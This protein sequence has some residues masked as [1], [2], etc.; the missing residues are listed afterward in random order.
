MKVSSK[1]FESARYS[2]LKYAFRVIF[3]ADLSQPLLPLPF[4]K[5]ILTYV[6]V[7]E[8]DVPS[9][10]VGR[11][12]FAVDTVDKLHGGR[13]DRGGILRGFP[14]PCELSYHNGFVAVDGEIWY[15]FLQ[16]WRMRNYRR[17]DGLQGHGPYDTFAV[18][19]SCARVLPKLICATQKRKTNKVCRG[20]HYLTVLLLARCYCRKKGV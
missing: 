17:G 19:N 15:C 4:T 8:V 11:S 1:K 2:S 16:K 14:C 3:P 9:M 18:A 20:D 12:S 13:F 5:N 7:V 10:H 6:S